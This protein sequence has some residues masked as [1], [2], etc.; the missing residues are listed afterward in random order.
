[1]QVLTDVYHKDLRRARSA[2]RL[3]LI[4]AEPVITLFITGP[5]VREWGFHCPQ[6]W[7]HWRAFT[8][9]DNPGRIGRGCE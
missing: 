3:A 2:H 7:R 1:D 6:G 8:A 9:A 5:R 4:D